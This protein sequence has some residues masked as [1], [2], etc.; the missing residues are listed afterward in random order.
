M[1]RRFHGEP[2]SRLIIS[3]PLAVVQRIDEVSRGRHP[4]R[5]NRSEFIRLA[6]AEKLESDRQAMSGA[7]LMINAGPKGAGDTKNNQRKSNGRPMGRQEGGGVGT[8]AEQAG[9][10]WSDHAER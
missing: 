2:V 5:G 3:V 9:T 6:I 8:E 10:R 4:A 7:D 1:T